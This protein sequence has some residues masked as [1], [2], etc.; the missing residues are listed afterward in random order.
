MPTQTVSIPGLHGLRHQ[1]APV[2]PGAA[3]AGGAAK[4]GGPAGPFDAVNATASR[5]NASGDIILKL[6]NVQSAPQVIK[7]ELQGA[8]GIAKE[9]KGEVLRAEPAALNSVAEPVSVSRRPITLTNAGPSF[10]HELPQHSVTVLRL[11]TR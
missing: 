2:P 8:S 7:I 3:P 10:T 6:V 9:A 11:K 5:E 1:L 4:G